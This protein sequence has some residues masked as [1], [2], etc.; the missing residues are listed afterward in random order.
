MSPR[1]S[2]T[3][4]VKE[5]NP[6][7][8]RSHPIRLRGEFVNT[9]TGEINQRPLLVACKDRRVVVCPSYSYLYK[10]DA[11]IVVIIGSPLCGKCLDYVGAVL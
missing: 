10:A 9:A 8:G 4:I 5:I 11:W 7:G 3:E 1:K 2:P 6:A